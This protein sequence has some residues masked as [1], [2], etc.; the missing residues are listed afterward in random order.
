MDSGDRRALKKFVADRG[1][2]RSV[3]A[4]LNCQFCARADFLGSLL[5]RRTN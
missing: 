2:H 1:G 5:K 4:L 3:H